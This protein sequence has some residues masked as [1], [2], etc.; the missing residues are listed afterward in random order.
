MDLK[1]RP[2]MALEDMTMDG[3]RILLVGGAGFIG[4]HLA[5]TLRE[6]GAEVM[7]A[8]NLLVNNLPNL[9]M[10]TDLD[11]LRRQLYVN[12]L[13]ERFALLRAS[14]TEIRPVEARQM[15]ELSEVF[16]EFQPTKAV[17]LAAISSAVIANQSP[18]LA[19]DLQITSL[20]NLLEICRLHSARIGRVVFMSSSTVY[21]DFKQESVDETVRPSPRGVYA[22]GKY[23]GERMMREHERLYGVPYTII[24]PSALY[25]IRCISGRVSQKFVEN[26]LSGK[27]L[28]L[29]GGGS[30]RLDFTHIDDLVEGIVRSM[31]LEEGRGRTFNIT[32]GNAQ[33]ISELAKIIKS[34]LPQTV[35]E[36][37]PPA[38]E[39]P[40]RGTLMIDRARDYLGFKPRFDLLK[41]YS[42]YVR[43]YMDQ[44]EKA[45]RQVG[46]ASFPVGSA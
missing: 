17:H 16:S 35:L 33:P 42:D 27:S 40:V 12:F 8:D 46:T 21:G 1:N 32:Y 25:G 31:A 6:R 29:E 3:E 4:H 44:W 2:D 20:R 39:K 26:A 19:Y 37:R 38:P 10:R 41:G 7:I 24:R 11:P 43:W 9:M 13:S 15:F 34:Y 5:L 18:A 23:M 22:N 14:G 36:E 45:A 30:G 28:P